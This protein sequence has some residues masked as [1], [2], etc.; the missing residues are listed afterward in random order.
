MTAGEILK[1]GLKSRGFTCRGSLCK[2]SRGQV[3]QVALVSKSRFERLF[4]FEVGALHPEVPC[5]DE[6]A[7]PSWHIFT[8][9]AQKL[10][11]LS[12]QAADQTYLNAAMNDDSGLGTDEKRERIN[13]LLDFLEDG[14]FNRFSTVRSIEEYARNCSI[15]Q[16]LCT[17]DL[18]EYVAA[19]ARGSGT[20]S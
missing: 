17:V 19:K 6:K 1:K 10:F 13:R 18:Q 3:V 20:S 9:Y 5:E 15:P 7:P 4:D 11:R 12:G 14:F 16:I 2:R 8:P